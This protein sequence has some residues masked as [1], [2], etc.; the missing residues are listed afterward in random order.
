MFRQI[1]LYTLPMVFAVL[2]SLLLLK[3]K[4]YYE[5]L[6]CWAMWLVPILSSSNSINRYL[7][8]SFP[9]LIVTAEAAYGNKYLRFPVL[10]IISILYLLYFILHAYGFWIA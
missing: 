9:F 7:I 5:L 6:Y 8:Q 4:R 3:K 1:N 2:A 10:L